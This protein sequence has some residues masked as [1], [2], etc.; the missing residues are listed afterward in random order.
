MR[1]ALITDTHW[2]VRNDMPQMLEYQK[3]SHEWFFKI[4]DEQK[5]K[6]CIHLGDVFDRRKYINFGTARACRVNFL[7]Q[8]KERDV[9]SDFIAGNHDVMYKNTN[10]INSLTEMVEGRYD[11]ITIHL[12]PKKINIDGL[13]IQ[14]MPW[15][16]ETN[17]EQSM[18]AI[19]NTSA[20]IIMGHFEI[21]G[22]E[23]FKGII[24]PHGISASLFDRFD[25]AYSGHFHH[26]SSRGPIY[27]LGAFCE[28][29]WSDHDDPRGFHIFDTDTRKIEFYQ[30]E[31]H[32]FQMIEYNDVKYKDQAERVNNLDYTKFKDC[33]VKIVCFARENPFTFETLLDNLYK[34][35]PIDISVV[36]DVN[37]FN[38]TSEKDNE[39]NETED[40]QTIL[41]KYIDGLKLPVDNDEM[42]RFMRDIY[43]EAISVEHVD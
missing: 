40:T 32:I 3:K 1:V 7:D 39:V 23:L 20:E 22:F 15:I 25:A 17:Y 26:Q 6:R 10:D 5:I 36:E 12:E 27:Y 9:D 11:N 28:Y 24:S 8:L 14:L 37:T 16:T 19:K 43:N 33:F 30:N 31:N 42:K 35:G 18:D 38:Q 34:A 4:L 13:D 41:T 21:E 2:G 29:V